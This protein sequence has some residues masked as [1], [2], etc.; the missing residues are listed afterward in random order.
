VTG[1][2]LGLMSALAW[3]FSALVGRSSTRALGTSTSLAAG[4][5]AGFTVVLV[6]ALLTAPDGMPASAT[7]G[8]L[9]A[10]ASCALLG[11]WTMLYSYNHGA[12]S[13]VSPLIACQGATIAA[14]S[15]VFGS[16]LSAAT[17]A[18]VVVATAGAAIVARGTPGGAEN[19]GAAA[20]AAAV[21]AAVFFG[22]SLYANATA[23][24][25]VGA[26]VPALVT[27]SLGLVVITLPVL[28]ARHFDL[29]PW[30]ALRWGLLGGLLDVGGMLFYVGS[31]RV[32]SV[33]VAGVLSSQSAAVST[34]LGLVVLRER[35]TSGQKLGFALILASVTGLA[36]GM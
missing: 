4:T 10:G 16:P 19:T 21:G 13:V 6:P 27:R 7:L 33:A 17:W 22:F 36:A 23:A 34:L 15:A 9:A 30:P 3:G 18:L 1:I 25:D 26:F 24:A 32:G 12:L 2:V 5:V 14:F 20:L 11:L 28:A 31:A 29:P 8:W 35:L